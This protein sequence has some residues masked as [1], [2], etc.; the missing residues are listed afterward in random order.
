MKN[1]SASLCISWRSDGGHHRR[2]ADFC[3]VAETP[4]EKLERLRKELEDRSRKTS[5]PT[6]TTRKNAEQPKQYYQ[7]CRPTTSPRRSRRREDIAARGH[8]ER[9]AGRAGRRSGKVA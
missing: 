9:K 6:K 1:W 2:A 3:R 4:A 7:A 5:R 8:A